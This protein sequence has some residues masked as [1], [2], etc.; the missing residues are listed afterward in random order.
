MEA[1]AA[2]MP[3]L[4][5]SHL[6]EEYSTFLSEENFSLRRRKNF[7]ISGPF[8]VP[9]VRDMD[10][11]RQWKVPDAMLSAMSFRQQFEMWL[12]VTGLA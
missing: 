2:G 6:G 10:F 9:P 7:V 3:A 1:P 8:S 11:V 12:K 5:C 4:L